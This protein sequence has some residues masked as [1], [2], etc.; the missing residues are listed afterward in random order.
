MPNE[1]GIL[2]NARNSLGG[3]RV[4]RSVVIGL[5][6]GFLAIAIF[7]QIGNTFNAWRTKELAEE[8]TKIV[9]Q[10][11]E[12][13]LARHVTYR[14]RE[15]SLSQA[16]AAAEQLNGELVAA[17]AIRVAPDTT[18][19]DPT[20]T[21]TQFIPT[22]AGVERTAS[23]TDTTE[24]GYTITITATAPADTTEKLILGYE[25]TTP[26]FRPEIAF[27]RLPDGSMFA[28]VS[29]DRQEFQ[30]EAPY[31]ELPNANRKPLRLNVGASLLLHSNP[32]LANVLFGQ[33]YIAPE[34]E[35]LSGWRASVPIGVSNH[36][37]FLGIGVE[38]TIGEW[39]GI[40]DLLNPF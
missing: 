6:L 3:L 8:R 22:S 16:V 29:W 13:T 17:L 14:L 7:G 30:I 10:L 19:V 9:L 31:F 1:G 28:S 26:E 27:I 39:S 36:G 35:T 40:L 12:A 33:A 5:V 4:G 37:F 20:S 21:E 25:F 34:Y 23:L 11:N 18:K 24:T 2:Q 15:D 38:K 32:D